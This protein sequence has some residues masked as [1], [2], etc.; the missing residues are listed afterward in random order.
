MTTANLASLPIPEEYAIHIVE[1]A[2]PVDQLIMI[3]YDFPEQIVYD[4]FK[5]VNSHI[6]NDE[7]H[8]G[9]IV[10]LS[11]ANSTQCTIEEAEFLK[12]AEQVDLTL[13]QLSNSEREILAKRYDLLSSIGSYSGLLLGVANSSWTAHVK[14]VELILKDIEETYVTSYNRQG[15]LNNQIFFQRRRM[16]FTRLDAALSRL[17]QPEIS[18]RI[19]PGDIRSNLGLSSKSTIRQW[20]KLGGAAETIP[21]FA[22]NYDAIAKMSRNL[23]RVGYLGM[24]LTGVDAGINIRKACA[25]GDENLCQKSKYTENA[26]AIGSI[27][28]GGGVGFASSYGVCTLLFSL[29]S[30]GSSMFWCALVAGAS[31]G[32]YGG[33]WVG[34]WGGE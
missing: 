4:H 18:G 16:H 5:L 26:K 28:G 6:K 8:P 12:V 24:V 10:L 19:L 3:L 27:A 33:K 9:Q 14:Q 1:K 21:N 13:L 31:G 32:Y 34:D 2:M 11:P 20:K 23:K 17:G 25:T 30:G 22:R 7:V 15:N 29:P